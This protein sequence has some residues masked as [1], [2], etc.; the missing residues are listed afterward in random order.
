MVA[1]KKQF[2][3]LSKQAH[4]VLVT[5]VWWCLLIIGTAMTKSHS[6]KSADEDDHEDLNASVSLLYSSK[7]VKYSQFI[8]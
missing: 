2:G 3:R 7:D 8:V 5:P 1:S 6:V 4:Y